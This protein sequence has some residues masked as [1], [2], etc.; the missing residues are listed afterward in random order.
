ME[1]AF[2]F[3]EPVLADDAVWRRPC[4]HTASWRSDLPQRRSP[5]RTHSHRHTTLFSFPPF[6]FSLFL[7]RALSRTFDCAHARTR[8]PSFKGL[9]G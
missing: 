2:E 3:Q 6:T 9:E 4:F 8:A 1:R 5:S 7:L